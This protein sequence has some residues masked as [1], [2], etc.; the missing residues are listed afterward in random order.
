MA[1]LLELRKVNL[2]GPENFELKDI[3]LGQR[4]LEKIG[5]AGETGAG[6]STLLKLIAGLLQPDS[7]EIFFEGKKVEGPAYQLVPGHPH[8]GY[9][10]QHFELQKSLRVE[11]VLDYANKL[12]D[13]EA[14]RLYRFC[15]IDHLLKR[16]TDELSGGEKQRVAICRL[17]ISKPRLLL[18]DEP[19]SHLDIAHKN[20]LKDIIRDI[21]DKLKITCILVSHDP[22]DT[23]AWAD[24][25]IAM[26]DGAIEQTGAPADVYREPVNEYVAG[27]FGNYN[28]IEPPYF[29]VF[30]R[31]VPLKKLIATGKRPVIVRPEQFRITRQGATSLRG[32]VERVKFYGTYSE[33]D[34]RIG[35]KNILIRTTRPRIETGKEVWV[36]LD[37][38]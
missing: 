28:V 4:K 38:L 35:K 10:S 11:Q 19:Y 5:I 31:L 22:Q 36:T 15:Q 3:E 34:V 25:V 27:L 23:L 33:V 32:K 30:S 14:E 1:P 9:L 12:S 6:K 16:R 18:L 37:R 21:G 2:K 13:R 7:G 24:T 20:S 29:R 17:L 26:K 8:I